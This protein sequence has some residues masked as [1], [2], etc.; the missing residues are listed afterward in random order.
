MVKETT[1]NLMLSSVIGCLPRGPSQL[2]FFF[3]SSLLS[4]L[5]LLECQQGTRCVFIQL[6]GTAAVIN[7]G[8]C[9]A[10][11]IIFY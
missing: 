5:F 6:E 7:L 10:R 1:H 3:I 8:L 4:V 11:N 2:P 9:I